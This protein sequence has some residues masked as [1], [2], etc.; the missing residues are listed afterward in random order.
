MLH[1]RCCRLL[2]TSNNHISYTNLSPSRQATQVS[3]KHEPRTAVSN[4]TQQMEMHR[5]NAQLS[6]PN[7]KSTPHNHHLAQRHRRIPSNTSRDNDTVMHT[8]RL[9]RALLKIEYS[10]PPNPNPNSQTHTTLS[11]DTSK[12][13]H[14]F[15]LAAACRSYLPK[16]PTQ[17]VKPTHVQPPELPAHSAAARMTTPAFLATVAQNVSDLTTKQR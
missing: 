15:R 12:R 16:E 4:S 14:T 7:F 13:T 8:F 3:N 5:V 11:S 17:E 1:H 9:G 2:V 6:P 10:R